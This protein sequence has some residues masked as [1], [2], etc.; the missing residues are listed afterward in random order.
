VLWMG[1]SA[2]L[3]IPGRRLQPPVVPGCAPFTG[4]GPP[5]PSAAAHRILRNRFAKFPRHGHHGGCTSSFTRRYA[6][7]WYSRPRII[8][9]V[10]FCWTIANSVRGPQFLAPCGSCT[11]PRRSPTRLLPQ[12]FDNARYEWDLL[13]RVGSH[14]I[15]AFS[16]PT[17]STL[18]SR[19][20][21]IP[22]TVSA[23]ALAGL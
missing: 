19:G 15:G 20:H 10:P 4:R 7:P 5:T 21:Y 22:C 9:P 2:S 3:A 6:T 16:S 11:A 8:G 17:P 14:Q 12:S 1:C 18:Q 23:P 13:R